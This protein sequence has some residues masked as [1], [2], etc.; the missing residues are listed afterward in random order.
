MGPFPTL[1]RDACGHAAWRR[2]TAECGGCHEIPDSLTNIPR[3][4]HENLPGL[5]PRNAAASLLVRANCKSAFK[6]RLE[7]AV[8]PDARRRGQTPE[9]RV[10]SPRRRPDESGRGR[11][12]WRAPRAASRS[13]AAKTGSRSRSPPGKLT[14]ASSFRHNFAPSLYLEATNIHDHFAVFAPSVLLIRGPRLRRASGP[15]ASHRSRGAEPSRNPGRRL[16]RAG[17]IAREC[18]EPGQPNAS[19]TSTTSLARPR[20]A[21]G[22]CG[23]IAGYT[24]SPPTDCPGARCEEA[25]GACEM[26]QQPKTLRFASLLTLLATLQVATSAHASAIVRQC[27]RAC[28]AEIAAGVAAAGHLRACRKSVLGRCKREGVAVCPC[29]ASAE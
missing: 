20:G 18:H 4:S 10:R 5:L 1:A 8:T 14:F 28:H 19:P 13:R 22:G 6:V 26:R 17:Q 3:P 27:R 2:P 21:H 16:D 29:P 25:R 9:A 11:G 7:P 23:W 15:Q 24:W 12:C